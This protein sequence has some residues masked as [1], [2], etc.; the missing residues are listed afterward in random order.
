MRYQSHEAMFAPCI[1]N[2][3]DGILGSA[4]WTTQRY[5]SRLKAIPTLAMTSGWEIGGIVGIYVAV[6]LTA[7]IRV[8]W[9]SYVSSRS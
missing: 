9:R 3:M 4:A 8:L 6:P 7:A 1:A 2:K 5:A